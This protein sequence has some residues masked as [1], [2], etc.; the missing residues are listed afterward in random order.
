MQA[1]SARSNAPSPAWMNSLAAFLTPLALLLP[2]ALPRGAAPADETARATPEEEKAA[3]GFAG[4]PITAL[5]LL[6]EARRPPV[7]YQ[8]R[9]EQRVII[10]IAP[11]SPQRMEQSL[12]E[13]NRRTNRFEEVRLGECIPI[14]MIAAVAPQENR[15]LLFMR[16]RRILSVALE[17]ACNPEDFYSG[18]YIERRDGQLCERRDHLQSRAGASCR[19]TRLNRLVAARD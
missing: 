12:A 1:V 4:A 3:R 15:L 17:R 9:I 18:F 16:D 8:V 11:S 2:A 7:E 6:E 13:L 5:R 19:V 10:R 14:N